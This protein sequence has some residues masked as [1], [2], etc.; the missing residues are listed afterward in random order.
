[1]SGEQKKS[2]RK[3]AGEKKEEVVE[4]GV[5]K[6]VVPSDEEVRSALAGLKVVTPAV[7][8]ERLKVRV[9]VAKALLRTLVSNGLLREVVGVNRIRVYE[10]V[11]KTSTPTASAPAAAEE[12]PKKARKPSKK[13]ASESQP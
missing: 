3:K 11:S 4:K 2:E 1:M 8:A 13:P 6:V 5:L 12:K 7:F 9:S 10:P